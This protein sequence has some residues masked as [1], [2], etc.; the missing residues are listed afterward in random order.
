MQITR[1]TDYAVRVMVHLASLPQGEKVPLSALVRASGVRGSFLSKVLQRLVRAGLVSSHRGAG[2]GFCL[3]V[4]SEKTTLIEVIEA[5]DGPL[6][7]N[8]CLGSGLTCE[9]KSWC[10]VHPIWQKAQ[11]ALAEVLAGITI[12]E[13]ARDTAVRLSK[14]G[15]ALPPAKAPT[16]PLLVKQGP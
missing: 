7:L 4:Q 8:L 3:R 16:E 10:G 14:T 2:G 12:A 11:G 13:L 6:Q 5:I 15:Q 9:R 1:A